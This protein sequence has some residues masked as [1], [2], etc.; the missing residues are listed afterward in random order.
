MKRFLLFICCC[1]W[2]LPFS[3]AFA[4]TVLFTG[5]LEELSEIANTVSE[6]DCI[7]ISGA[8]FSASAGTE[9]LSAILQKGGTV[10]FEEELYGQKVT[11]ETE[12]LSYNG[13]KLESLDL[14][15]RLLPLMPKLT[16]LDMCGT[17]IGNAEMDALRTAFPNAGIVWSIETQ[18]WTVR[19]D[20]TF[21]ATWRIANRDASGRITEAYNINGNT[22][23]DLEWLGYCHEITALDVGHNK[24]ENIEFVRNMPHLQYLI[25]AD[26]K[27]SDLSPVENL[28]ELT[29]LEI[30][31]NPIEDLSPLQ[32]LSALKHLNMCYVKATDL[33]P[34]EGLPLERLWISEN[35]LTTRGAKA[36]KTRMAEIMPDCN[37]VIAQKG[38]FTGYGWR[39]CEEY[40]A[41]RA[42]LG[43]AVD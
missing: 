27:V 24:L 17:G 22:S 14:F 32:G 21:F 7:D 28:T 12:S 26:N 20:I 5:T 40:Y 30:F 9:Q 6:G 33:S 29:Y 19:T 1:L 15:Y 41:M 4:D 11:E 36:V 31:S 3:G 13:T 16:S 43:W 8:Q 37:T 18:Y 35:Y 39:G 25:I 42:A 10:H 38:D 23:K 2:V 34:L